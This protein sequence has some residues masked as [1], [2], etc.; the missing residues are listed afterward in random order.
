MDTMA[1]M[2]FLVI[3]PD[4]GVTQTVTE[5]SMTTC[6]QAQ[7]SEE[8]ESKIEYAG[9]FSQYIIRQIDCIPIVPKK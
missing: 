7:R 9:H 2:I 6:Q 4:I 3:A 1:I 8:K 5:V